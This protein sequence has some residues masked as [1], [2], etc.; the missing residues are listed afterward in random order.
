MAKGFFITGTDTG[1]GKTL[2]AGAVIK[3]LKL[4]GY[5]TGAMKP[6]ETGCGREGEMLIPFDGMALKQMAHMEENITLIT[7]CCLESP[8]A[9]L[10]AAEA[11]MKEIDT[12]ELR[13]S[14]LILSRKYDTMVIEGIGGLMV[15]VR[16]DYYVIDI[17]KEFGFPLIL[18]ARPGL[19]TVN[20]TMLSVNCALREG[21]TVAGVIINYSQLPDHSLAEKTNPALL[22][23]VCPV[24]I[25]G[26][27]PHL[28]SMDEDA[29]AMAAMKNL[30]LDALKKYL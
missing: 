21:L 15:P 20:H 19:G 5:K 13:K 22:A 24:P 17:A 4:L 18:V 29:I 8:L 2:I 26:I 6:I 16:K 12:E 9:P 23:Q 30:D 7:P 10:A 27:F 14:L 1:V 3:A 11:D 28:K 25:L